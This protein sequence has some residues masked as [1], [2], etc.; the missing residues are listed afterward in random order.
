[1]QQWRLNNEG[2]Q[3]VHRTIG[4]TVVEWEDG[5]P[6]IFTMTQQVGARDRRGPNTITIDF[7]ELR[8]G[9][10]EEFLI[11]LKE[12]VLEQSSPKSAVNTLRSD[13]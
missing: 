5:E 10:A 9:F 4:N 13:E 1:M 6:F 2:C 11:A 3:Q 7:T 12:F 8:Q